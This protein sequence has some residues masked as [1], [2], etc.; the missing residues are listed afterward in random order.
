M[1][2]RI[3]KQRKT[4]SEQS[5]ARKIH[6]LRSLSSD[7]SEMPFYNHCV[8]LKFLLY[9]MSPLDSFCCIECIR[10]NRSNYNILDITSKQLLT[11]SAQ[12][13]YIKAELEEAEEHIVRL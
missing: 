6:L 12:H 9:K 4:S 13:L 8:Q 2:N 3:N 11:I 5:L 1:S 10:K 7:L